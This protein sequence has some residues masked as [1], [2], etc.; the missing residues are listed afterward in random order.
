MKLSAILFTLFFATFAQANMSLFSG[1]WTG[2]GQVKM[3]GTTYPADPVNLS[4][5]LIQ[6]Q[7]HYADEFSFSYNGHDATME[8]EFNNVTYKN[9]VFYVQGKKVGT[10]VKNQ[11]KSDYTDP[12]SGTRMTLTMTVTGKKLDLI[13]KISGKEFPAIEQRATLSRV[14]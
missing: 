5:S 6:D 8:S 1:E 2:A 11:I 14:P 12:N 3:D 9:G 7:V 4:L 13:K 10:L